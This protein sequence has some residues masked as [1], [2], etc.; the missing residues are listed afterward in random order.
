MKMVKNLN[1][2]KQKTIKIAIKNKIHFYK[3]IKKKLEKL[4]K[5]YN[6]KIN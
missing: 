4:L 1:L 6:K 3:Q 5:Q 2:K